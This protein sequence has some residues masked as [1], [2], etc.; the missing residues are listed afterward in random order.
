MQS[1]GYRVSGNTEANL[2]TTALSVTDLAALS[3]N[4]EVS[5]EAW[6]EVDDLKQDGPAR[7]VT[8]R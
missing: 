4:G 8:C 2:L 6:V 7:L 1:V 5:I 3:S